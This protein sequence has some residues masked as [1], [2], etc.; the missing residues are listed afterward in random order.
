M[1]LITSLFGYVRGKR[2]DRKQ[3]AVVYARVEAKHA[4]VGRA[5]LLAEHIMLQ[6]LARKN[7]LEVAKCYGDVAHGDHK[8]TELRTALRQLEKREADILVVFDMTRLARSSLGFI[9][10]CDRVRAAHGAI[11]TALDLQPPDADLSIPQP[12]GQPP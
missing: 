7:G 4:L 12:R 2:L 3:T 10:V 9:S 6:R 1:N 8:D 5:F 11:C